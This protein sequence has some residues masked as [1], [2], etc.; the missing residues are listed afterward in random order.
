M[1]PGQ[2]SS[3]DT[4]RSS[5]EKTRLTSPSVALKPDLRPPKDKRKLSFPARHMASDGL[6]SEDYVIKSPLPTLR[7]VPPY[8]DSDEF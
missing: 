3:G 8:L 4:S 1:I 5:A 6:L 2:S 7:K